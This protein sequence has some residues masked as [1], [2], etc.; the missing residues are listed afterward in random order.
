MSYLAGV[1]PR[2]VQHMEEEAKL[3]CQTEL[4]L[5]EVILDQAADWLQEIQYLKEKQAKQ[6]W[7]YVSSSIV[8]QSELS[9]IFNS[10]LDHAVAVG[11]GN[12]RLQASKQGPVVMFQVKVLKPKFWVFVGYS[13]NK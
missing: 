4:L 8:T 2:Q 5:A 7:I 11:I 9:A 13:V 3:T 1:S 6:H 12:V 10:Y